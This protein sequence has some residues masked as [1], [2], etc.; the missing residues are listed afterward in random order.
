MNECSLLTLT[1]GV[2]VSGV[3]AETDVHG[4]PCSS[5]LLTFAVS[6]ASGMTV[7]VSV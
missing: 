4:D 5:P 1:C 7:L 3:N 6:A 2:V